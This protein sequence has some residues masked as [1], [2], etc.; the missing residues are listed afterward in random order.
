MD[1]EVRAYEAPSARSSH[2]SD[3]NSKMLFATP[4]VQAQT[5]KGAEIEALLQRLT[6]VDDALAK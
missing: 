4:R 6:D 3:Q 2:I 5:T 1:A